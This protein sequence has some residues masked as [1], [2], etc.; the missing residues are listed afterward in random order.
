MLK[1]TGELTKI[2]MQKHDRLNIQ[3]KIARD[4]DET[5]NL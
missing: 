5:G 4:H 1:T 3:K 2:T